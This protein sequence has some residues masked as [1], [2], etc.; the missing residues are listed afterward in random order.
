M[1]R[2]KRL[3][4]AVLGSFG[5]LMPLVQ[6][7]TPSEAQVTVRKVTKVDQASEWGTDVRYPVFSS[8]DPAINASLEVLNEQLAAYVSGLEDSMK[9]EAKEVF[10]DFDIDSLSRPDWAYELGVGDTV[11][12]A[13]DDYISLLLVVYHYTGGAHG[14]TNFMAFN[15]D[16][17]MQKL[18]TNGELLDL[19][20][21]D[22]INQLLKADFDNPEQCFDTDPTMDLVSA[23]NFSAD[24]VRFSFEQYALGAYACG[25]AEVLVPRVE[26]GNVFLPKIETPLN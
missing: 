25:P 13:T 17:A 7:C 12:L 10:A 1:K 20:Q 16:V 18:L 6:S 9:I 23:I 2:T 21:L 14:M 4:L 5:L 26:L 22:R 3:L 19:T 11:Y 24:T 15:Y 8:P